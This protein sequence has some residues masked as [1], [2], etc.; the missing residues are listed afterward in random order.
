MGGS[1]G[2]PFRV[3]K[4]VLEDSRRQDDEL[5]HDVRLC[6]GYSLHYKVLFLLSLETLT[7][8]SNDGGFSVSLS[9]DVEL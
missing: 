6:M 3:K 9:R 1:E 2:V 8:I 4:N 5:R 7:L